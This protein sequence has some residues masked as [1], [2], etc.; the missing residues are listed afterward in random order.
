MNNLSSYCLF[1]DSRM[2]AS[3]TDLPV[4]PCGKM[5]VLSNFHLQLISNSGLG[6]DVTQVQYCIMNGLIKNH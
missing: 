6:P 1:S 2:R 5:G 3:D 4:I